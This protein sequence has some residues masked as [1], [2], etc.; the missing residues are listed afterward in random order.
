MSEIHMQ[1]GNALIAVSA[2][3]RFDI[4]ARW[5]AKPLQ[6][7]ADAGKRIAAG[8]RIDLGWSVLTLV[9][10]GRD[11][12][13]C[14]PDFSR[15]PFSDTRRD[16]SYSLAVLARQAEL[17]RLLGIEGKRV[18]F[19]DKILVGNGALDA[20]SVY[21]E[22]V[23]VERPASGWYVGD[24]A[25]GERSKISSAYAF[26]VV[27][28]RPELADVL[29]LPPGCLVTFQGGVLMEIAAPDNS[30]WWT[31]ERRAAWAKLPAL[32]AA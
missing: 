29:L 10:A 30:Q 2:N 25:K 8:V 31:A 11:L 17:L 13:L 4:Q 14:E 28:R 12:A 24:S 32:P 21:A 7:L 1:I 18:S 26:E 3:E 22:R 9:A 27:R 20:P 16:I 6:D 19:R 15:N 5:L 23:D